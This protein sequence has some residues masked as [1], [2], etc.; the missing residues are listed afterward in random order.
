ME[1]GVGETLPGGAKAGR[2][3]GLALPALID[4]GPQ[5]TMILNVKRDV[6]GKFS[7]PLVDP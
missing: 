3:A 1:T 4:S 7:M 6:S 5:A 2:E